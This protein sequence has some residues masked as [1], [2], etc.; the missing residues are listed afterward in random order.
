MELRGFDDSP[1]KEQQHYNSNTNGHGSSRE[2]NHKSNGGKPNNGMNRERQQQQQ[3]KVEQPQPREERENKATTNE[4][5]NTKAVADMIIDVVEERPPTE[6]ASSAAA[7]FYLETF[8]SKNIDDILAG[9]NDPLLDG[10][11]LVSSSSAVKAPAQ[12]PQGPPQGSRFTQ[13]FSSSSSSVAVAAPEQL[14]QQQKSQLPAAMESSTSIGGNIKQ[15]LLKPVDLEERRSSIQD[16]LGQP[17]SIRIPSP[18]SEGCYFAPISPAA[19]TTPSSKPAGLEEEQ[20]Q[21]QQAARP[22]PL[23]EL[24]KGNGAAGFAPGKGTSSKS[25]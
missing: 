23:M 8:L 2:N 6:A 21:Q 17:R 5:E 9:G 13:F 4:N 1:E 20:Q 19:Q 7:D 25:V 22:N 14:E 10:T 18:T 3:P 15:Q 24:L 11:P 16:E 12:E